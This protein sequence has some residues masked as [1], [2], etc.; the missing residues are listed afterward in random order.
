M[1][2]RYG[3]RSGIEKRKDRLLLAPGIFQHVNVTQMK[4]HVRRKLVCNECVLSTNI[5]LEAIG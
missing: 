2:A 5:L 1:F 3:R 4:L